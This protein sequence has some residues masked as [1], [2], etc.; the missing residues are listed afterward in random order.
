[1]YK[2]LVVISDTAIYKN[3]GKV[4][5]FAS[6]VHE[7]EYIEDKFEAIIW[8]G[9]NSPKLKGNDTLIE[10]KSQNIQTILI[11]RMGGKSIFQILK[12]LVLY[13]YLF[14]LIGKHIS[15]ASVIHT[16]APSHPAFVATLLSFLFP[17]K[18]GWHKF[19]GS[20]DVN[21]LPFFYKLQRS[22]LQMAKHSKVTINGFWP[23][24]PK[25]CISF[26][27]PCLTQNDI[28]KGKAIA[29]TKRF[30]EKFNLVFIGRLEDAKGMTIILD[31]LKTID[32]I[33]INQIHFIGDS[34][35][36]NYFEEKAIFLKDKAIFHGFLSSDKVHQLLEKAHFIILPS[37]SE[38]FPKVIA[39]AA[40]Y[41]VI[42]IASNVGSISHYVN[43][44]NGFVWKYDGVVP[45]GTVLKQA[46]ETKPDQ[47]A[48]LSQNVL[49]LAELFTFENYRSKLEQYILNST[50]TEQENN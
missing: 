46:L 4:F 47:L 39:E 22:I 2:Q 12:I 9:T 23:N 38:G 25:N 44:T 43:E 31:A 36:R 26:E 17:N 24:Q 28:L 11:P 7:L 40:C 20:W 50:A 45:F 42:P 14:L 34:N 5:G 16:R 30:N 48:Q 27:N 10:I 49:P 13:P 21:N 19:A 18:I 32:L 33:K 29:L 1:M 3:D 8:I 37:K 6:V 35:Q 41:G 15:N